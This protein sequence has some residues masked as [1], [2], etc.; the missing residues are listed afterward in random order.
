MKIPLIPIS[1]SDNSHPTEDDALVFEV[2]SDAV[3]ITINTYST[4][5]TYYED[6]AVPAA[7]RTVWFDKAQLLYALNAPE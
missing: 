6:E 2:T 1:D 5:S 7:T 4:H 3:G